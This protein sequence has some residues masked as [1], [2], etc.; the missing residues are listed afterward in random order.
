MT[1]PRIIN[2]Y[3]K[4]PI[5]ETREYY[6]KTKKVR[7]TIDG[8]QVVIQY[9]QIKKTKHPRGVFKRGAYPRSKKR[10][11]K[12]KELRDVMDAIERCV[13]GEIST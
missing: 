13:N 1:E 3:P 4:K 12:G 7:K 6:M 8:E 9:H 2:K 10:V 5:D 11:L